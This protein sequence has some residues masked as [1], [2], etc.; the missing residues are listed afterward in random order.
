MS[1]TR[2]TFLGPRYNSGSS[3]K[4]SPSPHFQYDF[5]NIIHPDMVNMFNRGFRE[6]TFSQM[7]T[8]GFV[9]TLNKSEFK[10]Y[11]LQPELAYVLLDLKG[12][13]SKSILNNALSAIK[14][15]EI[16]SEHRD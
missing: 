14:T 16:S 11:N 7:F 8:M 2:Q 5:S 1:C 15:A 12:I 10:Q 6:S 4:L 9:N 3:I 13:N